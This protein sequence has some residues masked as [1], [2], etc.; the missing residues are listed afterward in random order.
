MTAERSWCKHFS[1]I[2]SD[3]HTELTSGNKTKHRTSYSA[4]REKV[5][6]ITLGLNPQ[7]FI[8]GELFTPLVQELQV[9]LFPFTVQNSRLADKRN[10]ARAVKRKT[11][12]QFITCKGG[13]WSLST[14]HFPIWIKQ[15]I[16]LTFALPS[17]ILLIF[18]C[19]CLFF[20]YTIVNTPIPSKL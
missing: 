19:F 18:S 6:E 12:K 2:F 1:K 5:S 9:Y 15:L 7:T 10:T 8:F 14:S 17:N 11:G 13:D 20:K 4:R 3:G 16:L